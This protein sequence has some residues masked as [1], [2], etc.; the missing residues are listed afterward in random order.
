MGAACSDPR[1][2]SVLT[3]DG[4]DGGGELG[5]K[6]LKQASLCIVA[7]PRKGRSVVSSVVFMKRQVLCEFLL[8]VFR[9]WTEENPDV[10]APS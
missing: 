6:Q 5:I 9:I 8:L 3:L 2:R 4:G 10:V 1:L 7:C